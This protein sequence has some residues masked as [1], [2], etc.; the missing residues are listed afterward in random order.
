[1]WVS[2]PQEYV[3]AATELGIKVSGHSL[4]WLPILL[5]EGKPLDEVSSVLCLSR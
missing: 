3:T 5:M 1:M 4:G 2:S